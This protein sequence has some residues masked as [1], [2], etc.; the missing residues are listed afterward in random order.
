MARQQALDLLQTAAAQLCTVWLAL[1]CP[2]PEQRKLATWQAEEGKPYRICQGLVDL[3]LHVVEKLTLP[4]CFLCLRQEA[5][6]VK[7]RPKEMRLHQQTVGILLLQRNESM[8]ERSQ[9]TLVLP[10]Q[11]QQTFLPLDQHLGDG[12]CSVVWFHRLQQ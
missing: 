6:D 4:L 5:V 7:D 1:R 12:F 2:R 10:I 8:I 11:N 3:M 9:I